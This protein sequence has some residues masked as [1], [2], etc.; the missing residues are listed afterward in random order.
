[1]MNENV[2]L[3]HEPLRA[4]NAAA[5]GV[6]LGAI[7]ASSCCM[8]PLVLFTLGAGGPWIGYLLQLAPYQP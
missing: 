3:A 5:A 8:L 7:A 4:L 2:D 1:M 6:L